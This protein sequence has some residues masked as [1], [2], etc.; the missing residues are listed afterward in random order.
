VLGSGAL[1]DGMRK[2]LLASGMLIV[3][4]AAITVLA[5]TTAQDEAHVI[6]LKDI[7]ALGMP[8]TRDVHDLE[9]D[10]FGPR[11]SKLSSAEQIK[12]MGKSLMS[13]IGGRLQYNKPGQPARQAFAV[14]GI[15]ADALREAAAV[16]SDKKKSQVS[17]P[18]NSNI[19]VVFFSHVSGYYV[20]VTRVVVKRSLI[21]ISYRFVPHETKEMTSHFAL[22]P[23]GKLPPGEVKV[24]INRSPIEKKFVDAGFKEPPSSMDSQ[25]VSRPFRFTVKIGSD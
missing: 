7:W 3:C 12:I 1:E 25:I 9:P 22:I 23:I 5:E 14:M 20:Y 4:S 6:P 18:A 2:F 19:S 8:G 17:F 15:G 13:Q 10:K 16:L 21:E 11:I 24:D